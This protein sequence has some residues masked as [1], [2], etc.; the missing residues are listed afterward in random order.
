MA[1][2]RAALLLGIFDLAQHFPHL[3]QT[4]TTQPPKAITLGD[5]LDKYLAGA[6]VEDSTRA[7]Y[8]AAVN[9][10]KSVPSSDKPIDGVLPMLA[11]MPITKLVF[12]E[13]RHGLTTGSMRSRRGKSENSKPLA[14]KTCN[15]YLAVLRSAL[16]LAVDDGIIAKSPA[17]EGKKLRSKSQDEEPDPFSMD[18]LDLVVARIAL[19]EQAAADYCEFWSMVGLRTSELNGLRWDSVDLRSGSILIHETRVKGKQKPTTK[20]KRARTVWLNERARACIERQRARTQLA[21]GLVWANPYDG[22]PWD[23]YRDFIRSYWAP[24]LRAHG[25]RYRRPY[26][27]RHTCATVLLMSGVMPALAAKQLGHS[28]QT[29]FKK[30]AKWIESANDL[31]ELARVDAMLKGRSQGASPQPA[32]T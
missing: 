13:V 10:W 14:A 12:S 18:E 25:I 6:M 26:N 22:L 2:I 31:Q 24:A 8:I 21:G 32:A 27:L 30:Y 20:T 29:F 3:A 11:D 16:D 9:F 23:G 15:N 28:L 4:H 7:G 1:E 5:Q 19:K 17:G